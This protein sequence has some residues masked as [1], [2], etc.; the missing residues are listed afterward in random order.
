M[1]HFPWLD[2]NSLYNSIWQYG[3]HSADI[4]LNELMNVISHLWMH[5]IIYLG[6]TPVLLEGLK[7]WTFRG[8]LLNKVI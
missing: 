6:N 8:L 7:S 1:K 4:F 3:R 2:P 5:I